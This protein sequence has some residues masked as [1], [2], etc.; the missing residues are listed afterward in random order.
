MR[1]VCENECA[2]LICGDITD[3]RFALLRFANENL[4]SNQ[5]YKSET[6]FER[7]YSVFVNDDSKINIATKRWQQLGRIIYLHNRL[8]Q[9]FVFI[10]L[11]T[12]RN[13]TLNSQ[14]AT[15]NFKLLTF[16]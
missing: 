5:S 3:C 6:N 2:T 15:S 16:M 11:M 14:N 1:V 12:C 4:S 10:L 8:N 9:S 7:T 13:I